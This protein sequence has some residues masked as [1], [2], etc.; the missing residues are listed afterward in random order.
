ME[1]QPV[2]GLVG[3]WQGG[4]RDQYESKVQLNEI[5]T[6]SAPHQTAFQNSCFIMANMQLWSLSHNN[7]AQGLQV[8]VKLF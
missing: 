4:S 5:A 6:L 1:L 8:C 2:E 7:L 3:G